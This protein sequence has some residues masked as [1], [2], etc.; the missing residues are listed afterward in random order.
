MIPIELRKSLGVHPETFRRLVSDLDEFAL[1]DIR[2]LPG[3]ET[4]GRKRPAIFKVRIGIEITNTGRRLLEV[5]RDVR[6]TV[7]RHAK[8]LPEESAE[9]WLPA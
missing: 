9:H 1:I 7:Q 8:R 4:V 2:A 6:T 5:T 3:Q